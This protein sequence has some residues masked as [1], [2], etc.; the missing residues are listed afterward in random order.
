MDENK[1]MSVDEAQKIDGFG[2]Q[3]KMNTNDFSKEEPTNADENK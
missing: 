2:V 1:I 3:D